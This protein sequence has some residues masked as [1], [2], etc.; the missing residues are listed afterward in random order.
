MKWNIDEVSALE[1]DRTRIH[2]VLHPLG[3]CGRTAK[4]SN[5]VLPLHQRDCDL[6][7]TTPDIKH[8]CEGGV[9]KGCESL[10]LDL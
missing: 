3:A 2:E 10:L 6:T 7:V 9:N 5:R 1:R 8:R 4:D